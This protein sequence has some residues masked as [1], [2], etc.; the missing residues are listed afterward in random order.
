MPYGRLWQ[1]VFGLLPG[2]KYYNTIQYN[3]MT[4]SGIFIYLVYISLSL[5]PFLQFVF[6]L[7]FLSAH[8]EW[9]DFTLYLYILL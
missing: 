6:R 8:L 2:V 7:S 3:T 9:Q 4:G 1:P 5:S